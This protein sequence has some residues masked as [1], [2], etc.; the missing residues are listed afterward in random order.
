MRTWRARLMKSR[1]MRA[2][3]AQVVPAAAV[4]SALHLSFNLS[5]CSI[6]HLATHRRLQRLLSRVMR[7]V[8][9]PCS[10]S[11]TGKGRNRGSQEPVGLR[12]LHPEEAILLPPPLLQRQRRAPHTEGVMPLAAA[13]A[14]V[15]Q[16]GSAKHVTPLLWRR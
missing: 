2:K 4:Q 3:T 14:A 15:G 11:G 16:L 10:I 6:T 1:L 12:R 9:H 13:T 8:V 7:C 5:L